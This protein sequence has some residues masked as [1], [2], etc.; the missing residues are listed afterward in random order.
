MPLLPAE[1]V[2]GWEDADVTAESTAESAED[3]T[4][5]SAEETPKRRR[6]GRWLRLFALAVAL[7]VLSGA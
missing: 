2:D 1:E 7:L 3:G 6:R 4:E 5:D